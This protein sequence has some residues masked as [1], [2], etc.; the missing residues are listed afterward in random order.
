[1]ATPFPRKA[2]RALMAAILNFPPAYVLWRGDPEPVFGPPSAP[3]LWGSLRI[4]SSSRKAVGWDALV[5]TD[6]GDGGFTMAQVG[7]RQIVLSLDLFTW[8]PTEELFADDLLE[9]LSNGAQSPDNLARMNAM[10]LVFESTGAIVPLPTTVNARYISAA[11]VDLTVALAIGGADGK[12]SAA[13]YPGGNTYV[14]EVIGDGVV[15]VDGTGA[16]TMHAD[17][18]STVPP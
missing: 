2:F 18:K 12:A 9:T 6:T 15:T 1:M 3:F 10:G 16:P 8:G 13:R 14:D 7:R 5:Q 17:V 11:H 4:G